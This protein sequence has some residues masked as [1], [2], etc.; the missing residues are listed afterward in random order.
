M[1]ISTFPESIPPKITRLPNVGDWVW[2]WGHLS[3]ARSIDFDAKRPYEVR[4]YDSELSWFCIPEEV[5][6]A[7]DAEVLKSRLTGDYRRPYSGS[8][9]INSLPVVID[10]TIPPDTIYFIDT[11]KLRRY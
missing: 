8:I 2:I 4:P 6:P 5:D 11:S 1:I 3:Q 9:P 10:P 7:T